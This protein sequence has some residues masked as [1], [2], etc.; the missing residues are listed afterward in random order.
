MKTPQMKKVFFIF[1]SLIMVINQWGMLPV[2]AETLNSSFSIQLDKNTID[3]GEEVTVKATGTKEQVDNFKLEK[4]S[5]IEETKIERIDDTHS[6]IHL[7][8]NKS[9]QY[10]LVGESNG[11]KT[12]EIVLTVQEKQQVTSTD[13]KIEEASSTTSSSKESSDSSTIASSINSSEL[14]QSI[15]NSE[16]SMK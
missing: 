16:T 10:K 4:D 15:P 11:V 1:L 7:K 14:N 13:S 9:G 12:N 6:L 8:A 2:L 5:S 3:L